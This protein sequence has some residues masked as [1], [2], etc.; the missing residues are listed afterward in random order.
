MKKVLTVAL[1]LFLAAC[2]GNTLTPEQTMQMACN[3]ITTS[4]RVLTG[5]KAAGDLSAAQIAQ[6]DE[7]KPVSKAACSGT[8]TDGGLQT[9]IDIA[10][11]M[12]A[13][14]GKVK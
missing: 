4:V 11:G 3:S 2:A 12:L 14:E 1:V 9:V 5:Y 13:I 10:N 8:S 7:W 6:I